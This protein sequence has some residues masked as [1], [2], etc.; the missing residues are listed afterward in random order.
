MPVLNNDAKGFWSKSKDIQK[1]S[2]FPVL[3]ITKI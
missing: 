2:S 3:Q 1:N